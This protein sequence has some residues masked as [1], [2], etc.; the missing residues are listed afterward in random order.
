[1]RLS[2]AVA[3]AFR[4]RLLR[5]RPLWLHYRVACD[6]SWRTRE[7]LV[8]LLSSAGQE[9]ALLADG[10]GNWDQ[11]PTDFYAWNHPMKG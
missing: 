1:M 8:Q 3:D 10:R 11:L 6:K 5:G 2:Q 4:F 7:V 9:L